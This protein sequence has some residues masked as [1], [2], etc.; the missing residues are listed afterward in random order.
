[1]N[2]VKDMPSQ[3]QQ[4]LS[5]NFQLYRT[6]LGISLQE[7]SH[8]VG[9]SS[10]KILNMESGKTEPSAS[11]LY[12]YSRFFSV[13]KEQF[14]QHPLDTFLILLPHSPASKKPPTH[15]EI[16]QL[17]ANFQTIKDSKQRGT[18]LELIS[19]YGNSQNR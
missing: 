18:F 16:S 3:M 12:Y 17:I 6:M 4:Y 10:T 7:L 11:D 14:F 5:V 13:P 19:S 2:S 8:F 15:R 9:I 1:M